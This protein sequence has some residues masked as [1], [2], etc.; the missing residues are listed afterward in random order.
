MVLCGR[1]QTYVETAITVLIITAA[2]PLLVF[3]IYWSLR[4]MLKKG[5]RL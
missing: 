2:L 5:D 3:W 4:L 1:V